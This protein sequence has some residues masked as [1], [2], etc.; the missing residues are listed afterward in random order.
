MKLCP[1]NIYPQSTGILE[2]V[3]VQL[4]R[5]KL[6]IHSIYR[7]EVNKEENETIRGQFSIKGGS[8]ILKLL[9][10]PL[11]AELY[12]KKTKKYF[13]Q[14]KEKCSKLDPLLLPKSWHLSTPHPR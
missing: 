7:L 12:M 10:W 6:T 2:V 4:K 9:S 14:K 5:K 11:V 1:Y 8:L 3:F 13:G